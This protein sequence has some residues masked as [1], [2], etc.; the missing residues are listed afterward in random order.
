MQ[1]IKDISILLFPGYQHHE[2]KEVETSEEVISHF[3]H[4]LQ[5]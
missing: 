3:M 1:N 2:K 4:F 5:Q